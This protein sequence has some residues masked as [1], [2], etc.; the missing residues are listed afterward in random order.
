MRKALDLF[1]GA[2]GSGK[3]LH[4]A[5]FEVTGIDILPQRHYP[6]EFIK[7]DAMELTT[8]ELRRF[9]FIWAS[10]PCQRHS[11]MTKRWGDTIRN[12]H[13]DLIE[14]V[15]AMLKKSGVPYCIENVVGAPIDN[16]LMLCG[17]MFGLQTKYGSQLRRHR[18]F[19]TSF[20]CWQPECKHK[21]GSVIGV[22]GGGQHPGRRYHRNDKGE[23]VTP[24]KEYPATIGVYGNAGGSSNR[25]NLIQ[26]GTQD[27][28][29]AM[30]IQWMSGKELT[31][32]IPPT[33]S[34]YI[35]EQFLRKA[36]VK[37]Q[38]IESVKTA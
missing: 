31:Q 3:G 2:G 6:F 26:F 19:E 37:L 12:N 16:I 7:M 30:G 22:Y 4:D 10:P 17:S 25:D 29:D 14:P 23:L 5:G 24:R 28:R 21:K 34:K 8:E 9:D 36:N 1:C 32:A 33:Y 13:P 38:E 18:F 27:R 35:A 15:R 20:Y 11:V